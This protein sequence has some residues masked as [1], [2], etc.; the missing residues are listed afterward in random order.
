MRLK[1][2]NEAKEQEQYIKQI[3][4]AEASIKA[5]AWRQK[6]IQEL[7]AS[8]KALRDQERSHGLEVKARFTKN[9]AFQEQRLSSR[10]AE[11]NLSI[12]N[13]N[14]RRTDLTKI[15]P[16][17]KFAE[18]FREEDVKAARERN[19]RVLEYRNKR[20]FERQELEQS[21]IEE[22]TKE[23]EF[24]QREKDKIKREFEKEKAAFE[25]RFARGQRLSVRSESVDKQRAITEEQS[26]GNKTPTGANLLFTANKSSSI[27][28]TK[29]QRSIKLV[30]LNRSGSVNPARTR[31]AI[32]TKPEDGKSLQL[33]ALSTTQHRKPI[34]LDLNLNKS[35]SNTQDKL[36]SQ[37]KKSLLEVFSYKKNDIPIVGL[38]KFRWLEKVRSDQLKGLC[39][40]LDEEQTLYYKSRNEMTFQKSISKIVALAKHQESLWQKEIDRIDAFQ[41]KDALSKIIITKKY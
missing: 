3:T 32:T 13:A 6:M 24:V 31:L 12:D 18:F 20:I 17:K 2:F 9:I 28:T 41:F 25:Q 29:K 30:S 39:E 16:H 26:P 8:R 40:Q 38:S 5:E 7:D 15:D 34:A 10:L 33:S 23:K 37:H 14:E 1:K 4:L 36:A 11:L 21:R 19:V 35:V 22:K 27:L